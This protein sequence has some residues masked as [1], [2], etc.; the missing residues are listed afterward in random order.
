MSEQELAGQVAIVTGGSRG[1]GRGIAEALAEE[2]PWMFHSLLSAYINAGLL[3]P[4]A[5]CRAVE[6]RYRDGPRNP[7]I[8][9]FRI[10]GGRDLTIDTVVPL[11]PSAPESLGVRLDLRLSAARSGRTW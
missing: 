5:V 9:R 10:R 3:Q 6:Q 8:T 2:S 1:I 7:R 11:H 4:L